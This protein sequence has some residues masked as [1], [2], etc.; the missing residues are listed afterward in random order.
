MLGNS[1]G[2]PAA[3]FGPMN[4]FAIPLIAAS[5]SSGRLHNA[6]TKSK[7]NGDGNSSKRPAAVSESENHRGEFCANSPS[8]QAAREQKVGKFMAESRDDDRA[9]QKGEN[10][11]V[12]ERRRA[13][14]NPAST[15]NLSRT[16]GSVRRM[17]D[18]YFWR[19]YLKSPAT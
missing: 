19:S 12:R 16:A 8:G 7:K 2:H 13:N 10:R 17:R 4:E 5:R 6:Y 14:H 3:H 11:L 15:G 1:S 18:C 9:V